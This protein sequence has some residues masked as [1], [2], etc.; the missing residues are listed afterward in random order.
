VVPKKYF[1]K[2]P[3]SGDELNDQNYCAVA[4][5]LD[6]LDEDENISKLQELSRTDFD[7]LWMIIRETLIG[8]IGTV[9][10]G[11]DFVDVVSNIRFTKKGKI[12]FID[13]EDFV[14]ELKETIELNKEHFKNDSQSLMSFCQKLIP[15]EYTEL[16][17]WLYSGLSLMCFEDGDLY[18][19]GYKIVT[20]NLVLGRSALFL[21]VLGLGEKHK[22]LFNAHLKYFENLIKKLIEQAKINQEKEEVD[23][24]ESLG[25]EEDCGLPRTLSNMVLVESEE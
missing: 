20:L 7:A 4:E 6:L 5:E 9:V 23:E 24:E 15:S 19:I 16:V 12:A 18:D 1:Y 3:G 10:I 21:E 13:T 14:K 8:D 25:N 2:I 17:E 11:E 22:E